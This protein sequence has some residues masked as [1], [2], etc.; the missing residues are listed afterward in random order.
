MKKEDITGILVYVLIVA[1][2]IVFGLTVLQE[3]SS[4]S[5]LGYWYILFIFGAIVAGV[6]FNAIMFEVAHVIGAKIG[7]YKIVSVNILGFMLTFVPGKKKVSFKTYDGLTGETK[8]TPKNNLKKEANPKPY[9][10]FGSLFFFVEFI[11]LFFVFNMFRNMENVAFVNAGYF[12]LV[13]GTIGGLILLYNILPLK[14]DTIT[15]GYKLTKTAGQANRKAFNELLKIE[16]ANLVGETYIPSDDIVVVQKENETNFS[17]D[18]KLN[19]VYVALEEKNYEEAEQ[20]VDEILAD[21]AKVSN[22]TYI[23]ARAQKIYIHLLTRTLEE[24][25]EF[26]EKEVP[27]VERREISNDVSMPCI[28]AYI[29]MAGLLDKSRSETVLAA[30]RVIKAYKRTDKSQRKIETTLYNEALKKVIE[31]HPNWELEPYLLVEVE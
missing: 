17:A 2:A 19:K 9:L 18:I 15:D 3:H 7:G 4:A 22:K 16:Y 12:L 11:V 10:L 31:A 27:V 14:L 13:V 29:L 1:L 21:N 28:R 6:L 5:R 30:E 20:L 24:S 8:I 26:Y 25:K 23:R